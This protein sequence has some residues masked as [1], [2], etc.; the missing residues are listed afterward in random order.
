MNRPFRAA[1]QLPP[2]G[3]AGLDPGWSRL[4]HVARTDG[5]GR[6]WHLLD[7]RVADP[8]LTLLCVH[9][10]PSWSYLYRHLVASAPGDVRVIAVDQ[11]EMGWSERAGTVRRLARRIDDLCELTAE[12][13]LDGPVVTVA[14]DWGGPISLGWAGRHRAQLAGIVLM[15][16]A[17]HQPQG[18]PAPSLIR[19]TR[20]RPMLRSVTVATTA[21][22]RGAL[23]MSRPRPAPEVRDGFLAPYLTAERRVAIADFVA[24]IPLDP[25]HPSAAA[26]DA[27]A[28][29]LDGLRDVPALLLWG[30]NDRVFS[31]LYLHDLE[32]RLPH[33]DVHRYPSAGHFVS[34][35]ADVVGAIIDWTGTLDRPPAAPAAGSGRPSTLAATGDAPGDR[36]AVVELSGPA[37]RVSFT[38]FAE[39]VEATAAGLAGAGVA[40]G[41]RVA[42]MVP[43]GVDLAVALYACWRFG[44]VAVLIDSGLGPAGMSAAIAAAAPSHLIGVPKALA[45]ARTLRWPGRR[46]AATAMPATVRRALGVTSDLPALR[47]APGVLP[48]PPTVDDVAAVVFTSGST[49]PSKG[50][51]YTHG[52]LEAQRDALVGLFRITTDDRL[53]AAFAPFALFGP[54]MGITSVV[55][56]MDVAAPGTLT[57][58]AL[59]DAAVAVDATLVFASPAAL[60][61]VVRTADGLTG[62]HREAFA[63]VRVLMSAGAPV[64]PSLLRAAAGLFPNATAHTPYGMTECLPVADIDLA[65]IDAAG[66]ATPASDG[67]G[68][69][70][71]CVGEPLAGV[72]VR[73]R[74][75]DGLGR[76]SGELTSAPGVLGE[77][78]V[79][80][81]H[82]RAGYDR[83]W[84]TGFTAS[85][86]PGWHATGDV[87]HLDGSRR[88]WI[89]GRVGDVI[90]TAAGPIAPV[91]LE[92]A[93]EALDDVEAAAVVGVGPPGVQHVVAVVRTE[94]PPPAPRPAALALVDRV[95][96]AAGLDVVAVFE[97]PDL[98]VDR[99]H[100][101]KVDRTR[102]AAWAAAALA[103]GRPGRP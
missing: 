79:R 3:L 1:A 32:R 61:N 14:H 22:I 44:A 20:T 73:L 88:L 97:V 50:V 56:A 51:V 59:G 8:R 102:V 86:P 54:A 81:A 93:I 12:L 101:S 7:N 38:R 89:G 98:P 92:Q 83:L 63:R 45:A 67:S 41:D 91:R 25:S 29:G 49:G 18:S 9:G 28:A 71:V 33:A 36:P 35:D 2:A 78:V 69:D 37:G 13:G 30:A 87:G 21:F 53:V 74:P 68:G 5:V 15:N 94:P 43:P 57:A 66:G 4:V 48:S 64:R 75:L 72:E 47:A 46:I 40:P 70:G 96:Q 31:D 19:M 84:H 17:V 55:P 65:G 60:A 95:R 16:T 42:L 103:G 85:Q 10:N 34:E 24:D 52:R 62:E 77:V 39:L 26:L 90:A 58:A 27:I 23:A 11:L 82:A 76:A 6:T 99:R 100:N 80:A